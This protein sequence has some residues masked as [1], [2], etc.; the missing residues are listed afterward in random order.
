VLGGAA[1][2]ESV[3]ILVE[4]HVASRTQDAIL[5]AVPEFPYRVLER[6]LA[7][8]IGRPLDPYFA[9]ALGTLA[10]VS[11]HPGPALVHLAE[12]FR[13]GLQQFGSDALALSYVIETTAAERAEAT[14]RVSSGLESLVAMHR[15]RGLL[16][17]ASRFLVDQ[18]RA[19]LDLRRRKPLLDLAFVFHERPIA[20]ILA[21]QEFFPSCEVLQERDRA[22]DG[23]YVPADPL[24]LRDA[25][26]LM[27]EA[28]PDLWGFRRF[29]YV[30]VFQA[31][32][33][34]LQAHIDRENGVFFTS[35]ETRPSRCPYFT[36]CELPL[37]AS[38]PEVCGAQP[39]GAFDFEAP[40]SC[41]YALA[42]AGA[43]GPHEVPT[44]MPSIRTA[45]SHEEIAVAAYCRWLARGGRD[46]P[47]AAL[48][49]WL[50]AERDL[51]EQR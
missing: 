43:L 12:L 38:D 31:Q 42:V 28:P 10:L 8:L 44:R 18:T 27:N 22:D 2:E 45:P 7:H 23:D 3:A 24:F 4:E 19:A 25:L 39:W 40:A 21:F 48:D 34:Y 46:A 11:T 32:Q 50:A 14:V 35:S 9:A 15:S 51:A 17:G 36:T 1:I 13:A 41:W 26:V 6:T 5:Y 47:E 33:S 30:R 49:D 20:G 37:R 16:E 29:E